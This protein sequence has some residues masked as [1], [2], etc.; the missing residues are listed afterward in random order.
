MLSF[1]RIPAGFGDHEQHVRIVGELNL[2]H[3]ARPRHAGDQV[4]SRKRVVVG[5]VVIASEL[6][7]VV[8]LQ[9]TCWAAVA[10]STVAFSGT[11]P[12]WSKVN[13]TCRACR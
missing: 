12:R 9:S 8:C 10:S 4:T 6:V 5:V 2:R 11:M 7:A 1:Q 13:R 3:V